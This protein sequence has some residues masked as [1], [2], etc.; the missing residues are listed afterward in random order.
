MKVKRNKTLCILA[1]IGGVA[2]AAGLL[3]A[4]DAI[5]GDP[6]SRAWAE[7]RALAYAG[8]AY[9]DLTFT[10]QDSHAGGGFCYEVTV[11]ATESP[12][13]RFDVETRFWLLTDGNE[14]QMVENR[15]WTLV[16]QGV[17]GARE[18]EQILDEACPQY[19]RAA[20]YNSWT[21]GAQ[22]GEA[23]PLSVELDLC[24]TPEK[25]NGGAGAYAAL[26]PLDSAF[27]PAVTAKVPDRLC[28]Q[29]L[30]D[31]TPAQ[32]DLQTVA[33]AFDAALTATGYDI[34]YYDLMLV[35]HAAS[36]D[37]TKA[38]TVEGLIQK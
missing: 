15:N 28:A 9:P 31:G 16:R 17:E 23:A 1:G 14:A 20:N 25:P 37:G 34:D 13:T 10:V 24:W 35:P 22:P 5:N 19:A 29:I 2:I 38:K 21:P 3:L 12:D 30:W 8:R 7:H 32:A 6:L 18:I 36:Y 26:F 11:A 4:A 27:D 33:D